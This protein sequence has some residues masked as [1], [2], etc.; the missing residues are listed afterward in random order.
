MCT[1][2]TGVNA[3]ST[4]QILAQ[5]RDLDL[6]F[7]YVPRQEAG[8]NN[9]TD[10]GAIVRCFLDGVEIG[11]GRDVSK[12]KASRVAAVDALEKIRMMRDGEWWCEA[13]VGAFRANARRMKT[14]VTEG[15]EWQCGHGGGGACSLARSGVAP[16]N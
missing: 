9:S 4:L 11:E 5:H 16:G 12:K 14:P 1:G 13:L 3:R 8:H 6:R 10:G 7:D 2:Q 15:L